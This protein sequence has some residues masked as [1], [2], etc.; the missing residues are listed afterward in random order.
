M[1][2][3]LIEKFALQKHPEG[4]YFS[5]VYRSDEII[6]KVALPG[7]YDSDR[8]IGTSI[9]FLL[10]SNEKSNFHRLKSDEFWYFHSGTTIEVYIIHL[11]GK[12]EIKKMG[13]NIFEGEVPSL[14]LPKGSWFGAKILEKSS[15]GFVSC[16]VF[17]GFDF[18]DFE[19]A[20][21]EELVKTFPQHTTIISELTKE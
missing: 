13:M 8:S 18:A 17:P 9:Y 1:I 14:L 6:S 20:N 2:E 11:D 7:R 3:Q 4:G 10:T 15:Y 5:E 21:R 16:A 12:L 19:L